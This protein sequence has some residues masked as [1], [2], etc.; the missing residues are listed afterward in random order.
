MVPA[1]SMAWENKESDI[2]RRPPRE[3][4]SDRLVTR[5]LVVF[6]YLQIGVI[7]AVAGFYTWFVVMYDYGYP[8][9]I[10]PGLGMFDA[11][12]KQLL[13]CKPNS[14]DSVFRGYRDNVT[15][16]Y[17]QIKADILNGDGSSKILKNFPFLDDGVKE[18]TYAPKTFDGDGDSPTDRSNWNWAGVTND[19]DSE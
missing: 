6:S 16:T 4:G 13:W 10:L 15:R 2:M 17:A 1:I 14:D 18:C 3:A 9:H 11:W 8:A 7:Q 12:G 5:K 19:Y